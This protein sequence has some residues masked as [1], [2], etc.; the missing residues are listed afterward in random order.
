M[1]TLWHASAAAFLK[2]GYRPTIGEVECTSPVLLSHSFCDACWTASA[3]PM[4]LSS[5]PSQT[6]PLKCW[7]V[8]SRW[9]MLRSHFFLRL[10]GW[11]LL[12]RRWKAI[13]GCN[14]S[15]HPLVANC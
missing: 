6:W 3:I 14:Q 1:S 2:L 4:F 10:V 13:I 9:V 5:L 7:T 12:Q 11:C 8:L 15:A